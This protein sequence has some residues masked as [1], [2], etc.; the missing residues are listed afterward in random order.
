MSKITRKPTQIVVCDPPYNISSIFTAHRDLRPFAKVT[1][2][3]SGLSIEE[4]DIL[5]L[6]FGAAQLGW[7]DL[8]MNP[9]G[10]VALKHLRMALVHDPSLFARRLKK[11]TEMKEPLI[12]V[13]T[14]KSPASLKLHGNSQGARI[15]KTGIAMA[16]PIWENFR[17][18][19]AKL[20]KGLPQD[21]LEAH[22][23]VNEAISQ[24]LHDLADPT[25]QLLA[26]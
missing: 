12:E 9:E 7:D 16:R 24:R 4:A 6:L 13:K 2:G 19:E 11:L 10:F 8:P 26:D 17:K 23:R 25:K 20:L 18:V 22:V 15:T 14:M 1:L 3:N 21:D 5:M